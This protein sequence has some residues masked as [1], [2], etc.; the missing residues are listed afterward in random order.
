MGSSRNYTTVDF[1]ESVKARANMPEGQITF[2]PAD[3]LRFA[4]EEMDENVGPLILAAREEHYLTYKDI[5]LNPVTNVYQ[6]PY[7]AYGSKVRIIKPVDTNGNVGRSLPHIPID[8]ALDASGTYNSTSVSGF[9][10]QADE[11]VLTPKNQ[12]PGFQTMRVYFYIRPN[13]LVE[14][15]RVARITS[16]DVATRVVTVNAIPSGMTS[17]ELLDI[18]Q[19][20]PNNTILDFDLA[21][22]INPATK[23]ITFN[24]TLPPRLVVGDFIC[25]AGETSVPNMPADIRPLLEQATANKTLEANGDMEGLKA[26]LNRL[27]KLEK[28]IGRLIDNRV[29]SPGKKIVGTTSLLRGGFNR[30]RSGF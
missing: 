22:V 18:V 28:N 20:L 5:T 23:T 9:F 6:I 26:G 1:L 27:A 21:A 15:D 24:E 30:R 10:I 29:E 2:K 3:I 7:R 19:S 14:I 16:I 17:T 12:S 4:N 11:I 13:D 8:L 25:F